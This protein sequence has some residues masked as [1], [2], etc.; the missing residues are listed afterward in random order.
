M[1]LFPHDLLASSPRIPPGGCLRRARHRRGPV[2]LLGGG[3]DVGSEGRISFR[4]PNGLTWS[5]RILEDEPPRLYTIEYFGTVVTFKLEP[6]GRGGT[7][8]ELTSHGIKSNQ[9]EDFLPGWVSVLLGENGERQRSNRAHPPK[10]GC[11]A[12]PP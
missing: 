1:C 7:D 3:D 8:L 11:C 12:V 9:R 6:D 4:F 2:S 10:S 5:G